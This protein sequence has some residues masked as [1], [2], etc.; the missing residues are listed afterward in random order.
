L[1][2][3]SAGIAVLLLTVAASSDP[4]RI[5]ITPTEIR[6][7]ASGGSDP[8]V[9]GPQNPIPSDRISLPSWITA[10]LPFIGVLMLGLVV[11]AFATVRVARPLP[12]FGWRRLRRWKWL[13][14]VPLPEVIER[15]LTIDVEAARAALATGS[16]RN[17]IVAC[18]IQLERDAANVGLPR[19]TAET[20][21]EYVQR[22]VVAS[23]IDPAPI[24]E[25]AALYREARFS[26]HKLRDQD[27]E[28]AL[29]AL[30]RVESSLKRKHKVSA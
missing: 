28:R 27:R 21:A 20:P 29:D 3:V 5:W 23:S 9:I 25:L 18:W 24:K 26:L 15:E 8:V 1:A 16:P 14:I 19:M 2:G 17:A 4:S 12:Q 7:P 13:P 10:V 11:I 30:H 22:V 6:T